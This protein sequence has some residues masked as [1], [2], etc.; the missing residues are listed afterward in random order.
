MASADGD[1]QEPEVVPV[2]QY[3]VCFECRRRQAAYKCDFCGY[4]YCQDHMRH[5][6][7]VH[8]N[9]R[10]RSTDLTV[11]EQLQPSVFQYIV[12]F[13]CRTQEAAYNCDA[14]GYAYCAYHIERHWWCCLPPMPDDDSMPSNTT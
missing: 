7:P 6:C 13:E 3:I 14:C 12:C 11:T 1:Q 10:G 8:P 4:A 2:L 5:P 9:T